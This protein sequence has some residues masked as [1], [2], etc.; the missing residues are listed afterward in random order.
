M[1]EVKERGTFALKIFLGTLAYALDKCFKSSTIPFCLSEFVL[2]M[3]SLAR[4]A[5]LHSFCLFCMLSRKIVILTLLR[6]SKRH[7][8]VLVWRWSK[9]QFRTGRNTWSILACFCLH[10]WTNSWYI[11]LDGTSGP[12]LCVSL[13]RECVSGTYQKQDL[14]LRQSFT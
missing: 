13:R 5:V 7:T 9:K 11:S 12:M 2:V 10:R 1:K 14:L 6:A 3:T 8:V 4:F